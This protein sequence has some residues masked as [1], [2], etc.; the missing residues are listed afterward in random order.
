MEFDVVNFNG[1]VLLTTK[2]GM[3]WNIFCSKNKIK[4]G[5]NIQFKF[6]IDNPIDKCNVYKLHWWTLHL[7]SATICDV[8]LYILCVLL[9]IN[10]F[11]YL[12][13][14]LFSCYL[15]SSYVY[16]KYFNYMNY[17]LVNY[18][19]ISVIVAKKVFIYS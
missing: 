16:L 3:G 11:C 7:S 1:I 6:F 17:V 2:S 4:A 10:R 12:Y 19:F 15:Y 14:F 18:T 13:L 5:D 8:C 9:N